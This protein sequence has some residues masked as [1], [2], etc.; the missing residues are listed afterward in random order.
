MSEEAPIYPALM[1][2]HEGAYGVVFPAL[3]GCVA[4][5][6]TI[7]DALNNAKD[8]M[9]DWMEEMEEDGLHISPPSPLLSVDV[10]EG[11]WLTSVQR[12]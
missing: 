7:K 1:D 11:S 3:P 2:G 4:M 10:P 8:A 12:P 9:K 6:Y 5:G